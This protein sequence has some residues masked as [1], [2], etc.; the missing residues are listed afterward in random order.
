MSKWLR[1]HPWTVLYI[2]VCVTLM[3]ILQVFTIIEFRP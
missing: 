1:D 2:A 3:L